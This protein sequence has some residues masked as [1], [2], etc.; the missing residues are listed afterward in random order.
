MMELDTSHRLILTGTASP[1][2]QT[3]ILDPNGKSHIEP[4]GDVGMGIFT[5]PPQQ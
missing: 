5:T 2:A 1:A 4:Q 3:I